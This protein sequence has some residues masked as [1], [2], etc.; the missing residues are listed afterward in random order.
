MLGKIRQGTFSG[1]NLS[2]AIATRTGRGQ[3]IYGGIR[4]ELQIR[5]IKNL[6]SFYKGYDP[7]DLADVTMVG[8]N[9]PC[10][11]GGAVCMP[12]DVVL[13]TPGG[14]LFIAPRGNRGH[15]KR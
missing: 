7:T 11:I 3:V 4:D 9:V 12:G 2:T 8:M 1:G 5:G 15:Q 10:R 6:Q 13:G 14:I